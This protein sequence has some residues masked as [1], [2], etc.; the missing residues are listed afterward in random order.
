MIHSVVSPRSTV[1]DA[2]ASTDLAEIVRMAPAPCRIIIPTSAHRSRVLRTWVQQR[3]GED[4]PEVTTM[5]GFVM[6]LA[7]TMATHGT[8]MADDEAD[9]LLQLAMHEAGE[10]FRPSGLSIQRLVRWKQ[11]GHT[12]DSVLEQVTDTEA[13]DEQ[14]IRDVRRIV[15]VWAAYEAVKGAGHRD[16]GDLFQDLCT[17]VEANAP[18]ADQPTIVLSTHGL[19]AI[20]ERLMIALGAAGWDVG[21]QFA[22]RMT[23]LMKDRSA[24][25]AE[26]LVLQGWEALETDGRRPAPV[27]RYECPTPREE[28]R[29]ILGAIKE[30]V[31]TGTSPRELAI[32]LPSNGHY[33]AL[34]RDL[35]RQAGVPLDRT[36]VRSL[37][38]AGDAAALYAACQVVIRQWEREDLSRLTL[39]G[40]VRSDIPLAA[41][42][43]AADHVRVQGGYGLHV[44][45][46]RLQ[47]TLRALSEVTSSEADDDDRSL[48]RTLAVLKAALSALDTLESVL[49]PPARSMSA[50]VFEEY[51]ATHLADGLGIEVSRDVRETV[52]WYR[53]IC[54]RHE[55]PPQPLAEHCSRW[56]AIVRGRSAE[57][58]ASTGGVAVLGTADA[59]LGGYARVFAPGFIDGVFPKRRSDVVEEFFLPEADGT[60][61]AEGL[62]DLLHAAASDGSIIVTRAATV[63]EDDTLASVFWDDLKAWIGEG[64]LVQ[65]DD[66][67]DVFTSADL[68][69]LLNTD[70]HR[71]W[72]DGVRFDGTDRQWGLH[73]G[74]IPGDV[75]E[76]ITTATQVALN[77]SRIDMARSCP[78]KYYGSR[79]LRLEQ[80]M[81]LDETLSPLERGNLMHSVAQVFLKDRQTHELGEQITVDDLRKAQVQIEQYPVDQL[82]PSLVETF[83]REREKFPRGYLYDGAE[84]R[85]FYDVDRRAG[86]LRRWLTKE[87]AQQQRDG[88]FPVLFELEIEDTVEI[89]EG[90]HEAV[91]IRVD[92][93]DARIDED[94][95]AV[96]VIDYKTSKA[97]TKNSVLDGTNSQMPLYMAAVQQWFA[98]RGLDVRVLDAAYHTFGKSLF[99]KSAPAVTVAMSRE[100][101]VTVTEVIDGKKVKHEEIVD[102]LAEALPKIQPG[103]DVI[104]QRTFA[105]DPED[106]ACGYCHLNELCRI[107]DWG[108]IPETG[109]EEGTA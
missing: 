15:K 34:L 31:R 35:A 105:V 53:Q 65:A 103:I 81:E 27:A 19:T 5:Q 85:T 84:E 21:I 89:A 48:R 4:L 42:N 96:R 79:L 18:D 29:R 11:E 76:P 37:A 95:I 33:D 14:G 72:V 44:W 9:L 52:A 38:T 82:L 69:I 1:R 62:Q 94:R 91:K 23:T 73:P 41:L 10:R 93:V 56:W 61:D 2:L 3:P 80:T 70:E 60:I 109:G 99:T 74:T 8:L 20:D 24:G 102:D 57:G 83:Q 101:V 28:V 97:P 49:T 6:G 13:L 7:K 78:Y 88:F 87:I 17:Q 39:S 54:E 71:A 43:E 58:R 12:V 67:Y 51:L 100:R 66:R 47:S 107:D 106:E 22:E 45:R 40:Q 25:V 86:L 92:R 68:P 64:M 46:E 90:R 104:R 98:A 26:R 55:L 59:R 63:D 77:P 16:R 36:D 108:A 30:E 50:A 32:I 75:D